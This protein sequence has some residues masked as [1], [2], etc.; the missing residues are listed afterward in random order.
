VW[1]VP[2]L[3]VAAYWLRTAGGHEMPLALA[4]WAGLG[5][6]AAAALAWPSRTGPRALR[7]ALGAMLLLTAIGHALLAASPLP[8]AVAINIALAATGLLILAIDAA[9]SF[10]SWKAIPSERLPGT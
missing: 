7:R 4:F 6:A 8:D 2:I 9:F 3:F 5:L 10:P 1:G